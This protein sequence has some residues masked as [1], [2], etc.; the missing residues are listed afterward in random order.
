[1]KKE[2]QTTAP[3]TNLAKVNS[4]NDGLIN[5]VNV[6]SQKRDVTNPFSNFYLADAMLDYHQCENIYLTSWI[7]KKVVEIPTEY[8]FKNG[9]TVKIKDNEELEKVV[10]ELYK[11]LNL[12][13]KIK[14]CEHNKRIYGGG[15]LFI[16]NPFQDLLQKFDPT[17]CAV[18]PSSIDFV[19]IDL[20]Y[21]AVTPHINIV[22]GDYFTPK[23]IA[24]AGLSADASNCIVFRGVQV[25]KRRMPNFKYIGM[26]VF[27][28]IFQAMIMDDYISKGIANM[29][30]R[31]NRWY[32]KIDGLSEMAK[33]GNEALALTRLSMVEDS[34]NILSAG[35]IDK[36]DEVEMITQSFGSLP[37]VDKRSL[38][39]LSAACNIPATVLLG[40]SPDGMNA[41]GD[42]DLENFY[43]YVESEQAKIVPQMRQ[44]FNVL[45][46][47][48]TGKEME[49]EF[50]WN[51][52]NQISQSK[53]MALD[54]VV[55]QNAQAMD[56]IGIPEDII[57]AYMVKYNLI[58]EQQADEFNEFEKEMN[59]L[60]GE[61]E[62]DENGNPIEGSGDE[63]E[64][65]NPKEPKEAKDSI[66]KR[67]KRWFR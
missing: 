61:G 4:V 27:Q 3:Q 23:T 59:A 65:K 10:L 37:D 51:K 18:A 41:T 54:T 45:I 56:N 6:A 58:S 46:C 9:F 24:M 33:E 25:P 64:P 42:S 20:S 39:R 31:N 49:F 7:A 14:I 57:K 50:E 22:S 52:P 28:N 30:W 29:V 34:M 2:K 66:M 55:L 67:I 35:I 36:N 17:A 40:K 63:A 44:I 19:T 47:M 8:I 5:L 53:Q 60:G 62:V 21:C 26:S 11:Q 16:K 38:E 1:M 13:D 43:N 12:E 15:I 32:Y 48:V